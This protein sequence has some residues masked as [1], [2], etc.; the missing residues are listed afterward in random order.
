MK[1]ILFVCTGNTCRSPMAQ[2]IFNEMAIRVGLAESFKADSAGI[3]VSKNSTETALNAQ[4]IMKE[5]F[6]IDIS[7]YKPKII[8]KKL[9]EDADLILCM[10]EGMSDFLKSIKDQN[11]EID[12]LG[13]YCGMP[14]DVLDPYGGN[15][16]TY[17]E[18]AKN[19]E[20]L[21]EKLMDKLLKSKEEN[22]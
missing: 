2:A 11:L 17:Y 15:E 7:N 14:Q 1:N 10:E 13:N 22:E 4:K 18:C 5:K 6:D 3:Y 20:E 16:D 19:I 12:T 21:I 8:S 9:L